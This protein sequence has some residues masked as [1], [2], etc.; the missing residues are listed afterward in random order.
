MVCTGKLSVYLVVSQE[1]NQGFKKHFAFILVHVSPS[2]IIPPA[3]LYWELTAGSQQQDQQLL[4][5]KSDTQEAKRYHSVTGDRSTW[6]SSIYNSLSKTT[7]LPEY[8]GFL[9][10]HP[11]PNRSVSNTARG[12]CSGATVTYCRCQKWREQPI[13]EKKRHARD[14]KRKRTDVWGGW[15]PDLLSVYALIPWGW[16]YWSIWELIL[17]IECN[18][19]SYW[20]LL[21]WN[22]RVLLCVHFIRGTYKRWK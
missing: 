4:H 11:L 14:A 6:P 8:F 10:L 7:T 16:A 2:W 3:S 22:R 13:S 12:V 21:L 20:K 9:L 19:H 5:H 15:M 17:Q 18:W 1:K